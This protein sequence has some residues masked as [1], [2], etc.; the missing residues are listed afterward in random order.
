MKQLLFLAFGL[1]FARLAP[2]QS[3]S[4]IGMW[5]NPTGDKAFTFEIFTCGNRLCGKFVAVPN[6][7]ATGKPLTDAKNPDPAQR[8]RSRLGLVFIQNFTADG[9]NKWDKGKIYNPEDG[10]TYSASLTM[11]T[12]KTLELR[13]YIGFSLLGQT[14]TWTRLK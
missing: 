9:E 8:G 10:R 5:K 6:D 13:G 12:P 14:Q 3:L 2:A 4:P 1:G 7:P 11:K